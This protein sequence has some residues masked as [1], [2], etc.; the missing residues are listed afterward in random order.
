VRNLEIIFDQDLSLDGN[1]KQ[2][3]RTVFFYLRNIT[4]NRI[5][6][7]SDAEKLVHAFVT[8]RL[9]DCNFCYQAVPKIL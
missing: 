4:K 7:E 1:V 6:S 2:V 9:N 5:V 3:P 8:S